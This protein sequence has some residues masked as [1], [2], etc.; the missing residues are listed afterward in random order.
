MIDSQ[1]THR[2]TGLVFGTEEGDNVIVVTYPSDATE[3]G[4]GGRFSTITIC[5]LRDLGLFLIKLADESEMGIT[6]QRERE[7]DTIDLPF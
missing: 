6:R 1:H 7:R 2:E 5:Q 3:D 4:S